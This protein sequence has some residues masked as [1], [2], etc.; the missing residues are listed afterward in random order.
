MRVLLIVLVDYLLRQGEVVLCSCRLGIVEDCRQ[1]MAR[2]LREFYVSLY[3]RLE[4]E[5]LEMAL[6]LVVYLP[7]EAETLVIHRQQEAF[8][9]QLR[10]EFGLDNLDGV[11]QLALFLQEQNTHTAQE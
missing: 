8:Y 2:C 6:H 9:L 4:D 11:E 1:T 3:D 7:C 10:V 5:F